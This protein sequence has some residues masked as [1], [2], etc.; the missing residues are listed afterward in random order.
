MGLSDLE[1]WLRAKFGHGLV[2]QAF[3]TAAALGH[4]YVEPRVTDGKLGDMFDIAEATC[5]YKG[6]NLSSDIFAWEDDGGNPK[7]PILR[8]PVVD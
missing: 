6:H 2:N 8:R 7:D 5:F 1:R 4:V 3:K